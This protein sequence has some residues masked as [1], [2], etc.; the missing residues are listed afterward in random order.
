MSYGMNPSA[1]G[2]N[3][4]TFNT[5][6]V[7][8]GSMKEKIP[9]GYNKGS[10][11]QFTPEQMQLFQQMF[12]HVGPESYLSKLAGGDQSTFGEIEA[13]AL[14]QFAGL[15]GNIASR[16][17]GMGGLGARKS[18]G[19]QNTMNSAA[20]NFAQDLQS[21]RQGLQRQALMD[22]MGIS[23]SLLGQRPYENFLVEKQKKQSGLGGTIGAGIGGIGGFFAGGPMGA[24]QG[25]QLGYGVGSQF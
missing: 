11:Q 16:F 9:S 18:S 2:V 12:G 3:P 25:A 19:F 1:T 7:K 23:N 13:P 17:S 21:Q 20:S 10:L 22:L 5:G 24:L 6:A 14:R 8:A 15:Q 4:T